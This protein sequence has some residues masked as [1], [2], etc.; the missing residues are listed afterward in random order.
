MHQSGLDAVEV[1]LLWTA[2]LL[3]RIVFWK[4]SRWDGT[5]LVPYLAWVSFSTILNITIWRMNT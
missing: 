2:I 3:T 5:L 4:R 1:I